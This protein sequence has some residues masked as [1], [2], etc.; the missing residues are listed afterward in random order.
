MASP[1]FRVLEHTADV[2][3]EVFG[4]T[5]ADLFA[6]AA[7]G[8]T[9]LVTDPALLA[10]NTSFTLD[11]RAENPEEL[12]HR[13]LS[14]LIY[15]FDAQGMIFRRAEILEID[16]THIKAVMRGEIFD[17]ARHERRYEIKAATLHGLEVKQE[18][19]VF[20]ARVLFDI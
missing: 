15:V 7:L 5:L 4:D 18:K 13:W 1:P 14:E 9:D 6:H 19:G 20:R 17:P 2:G 8:F 10:E 12:L 11:V 3:L 16:A